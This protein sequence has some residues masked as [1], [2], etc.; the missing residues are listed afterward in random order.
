MKSAQAEDQAAAWLSCT[1]GEDGSCALCGDVALPARVLAV[2]ATANTASVTMAGG[3]AMVALDLVADVRPGDV[4]LVHQ[5]FAI[6]HLE[7]AP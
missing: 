1:P 5:G 6:E 2:D 7:R 3:T 4:L